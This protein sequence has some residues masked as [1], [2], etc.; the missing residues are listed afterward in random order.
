MKFIKGDELISMDILFSL[1]VEN[2]VDIDE[3]N[4]ELEEEELEIEI[5]EIEEVESDEFIVINNIGFWVLVIIINGY[6][7]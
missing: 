4:L 6:G 3:E 5:D 1:I 7:K 2:I